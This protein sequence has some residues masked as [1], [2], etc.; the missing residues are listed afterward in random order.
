MN[1][2]IGPLIWAQAAD[3]CERRDELDAES[4]AALGDWLAADARHRR[5]YEFLC[6]EMDGEILQ[7]SLEKVR[8]RAGSPAAPG[9]RSVTGGGAGRAAHWLMGVAACLLIAALWL[10]QLPAWRQESQA[11]V[12]AFQ[13]SMTARGETGELHTADG[14]HLRL[15]GDTQLAYSMAGSER[16]VEL[17]QGEV[18]FE[19]APDPDRPFV[20]TVGASRIEVVGTVFNVNRLGHQ[21]QVNV[22][23]GRVRVAAAGQRELTAGDAILVD[24]R[25]LEPVTH[26]DQSAGKADW[27]QNW[28]DVTEQPLKDVLLQLQRHSRRDIVL[29]DILSAQEKVSGRFRLDQPRRSLELLADLQGLELR[30]EDGRYLL[31]R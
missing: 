25:R 12:V 27:M 6:A 18:F 9:L 30:E 13:E 14:S 17:R 5:A 26:F 23:E 4:R 20:I 19:V 7:Y 1:S 16:R 15:N 29:A 11:P 8:E 22:Y 10:P 24:G 31:S 21:V 2:K 3:W 28:L